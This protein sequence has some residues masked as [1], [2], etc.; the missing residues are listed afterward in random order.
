MVD[1]FKFFLAVSSCNLFQHY[2]IMLKGDIHDLNIFV[3]MIKF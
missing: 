2:Y 3:T 1:E